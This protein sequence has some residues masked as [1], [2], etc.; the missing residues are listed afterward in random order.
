MPGRKRPSTDQP[1]GLVGALAEQPL[2]EAGRDDVG[3]VLVER[4]G[5]VRVHEAGGVLGQRVRQLVAQHVD[6]LGEPVEDHA[7]AVAEDELG[8]VPERVGV[9]A[10]VVHAQR[11]RGAGAVVG[12]APPHLGQQRQRGRDPG[13]G[14]VDR[15]VADGGLTGGAGRAARQR[16][17]RAGVVHRPGR[18]A[19]GGD[20]RRGRR[21]PREPRGAQRLVDGEGGVVPQRALEVGRDEAAAGVAG[22][23]ESHPPTQHPGRDGGKTLRRAR[24]P[25]G[26]RRWPP[27]PTRRG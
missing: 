24:A 3:D 4:A 13:R 25:A 23:S 1:V 15:R 26:T 2:L 11:H 7:V 22:G 21:G 12:D 14:L 9:V 8:A 10:A 20:Q 16:R 6:G 17:G 27:D 5:L 19:G 18:G